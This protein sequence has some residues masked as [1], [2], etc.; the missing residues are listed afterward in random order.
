MAIWRPLVPLLAAFLLIPGGGLGQTPSAG[1]PAPV[2]PGPA[3]LTTERDMWLPFRDFDRKDGLRSSVLTLAVDPRGY[4]YA[5]TPE[6]VSRYNGQ[7]WT[8]FEI[9]HKGAP[10]AVY[11]VLGTSEGALWFG[12]DD[13][14]LYRHL[15]DGDN[16]TDDDWSQFRR[17]SGLPADHVGALAETVLGGYSVVWAGTESGLARCMSGRCTLVKSVQSYAVLSLLPST[18]QDG[19]PFLWIGTN[20][21]LL[22]LERIDGQDPVLAPV[23]FNQR[24]ALPGSA[25]RSLAETGSGDRRALWVGTDRGLSVLRNGIWTRYN[26]ASGFP[27]GRVLSL[28]P[29]SFEGKSVMWA[30]VFGSGLVLLTEDGSWQLFGMRSGLLANLVYSLAVTPPDGTLW[31]ATAAGVSRLERERWVLIDSRYG[32]PSSFTI[33]VGEA[34]FPDG[35]QTFWVGTFSGIARLT[36]DGWQRFTPR[37]GAESPVVLDATNTTEED[38]TR[39]F[40]MASFEG[41]YRHARGRW[42]LLD[43]SNS[44]LPFDWTTCLLATRGKKGDSLW[45][46][47]TNGLALLEQGRWT[48]FR[49]GSGPPGQK[50]RALLQTRAPGGA[51]AVWVGTD[52]GM[53]RYSGGRWTRADPPCLPH[54]GVYSLQATTRPDGTGWLWIGTRGGLARVRIDPQGIRPS[55]CQALTDAT[56]PVR[57]EDPWITQIQTDRYGRVYLFTEQG[58]F[59]LA[60][61]SQQNLRSA[62]VTNV[63]PEVRFNRA[64]FR[65]RFGRIWAASSAGAAILGP[66]PPQSKSAEVEPARLLFEETWVDGKKREL[67]GA[68]LRHD[69]NSLEIEYALLSYRREHDIRFQTQLDGLE[70][71]AG[72]WSREARTIFNKLPQGN[73]TFR[74]WAREADGEPLGPIEMKF[75]VLPAPWKTWW[76]ILLYALALTGL[77]YGANRLR[78][79]NL[80]RRAELLE[81]LVTDRTRELAEANRKLEMMSVTDPLTALHNRRFVALNLEADLQRAIRNYRGPSENGDRNRD[82]LLYLIDL[83]HFKKVNDRAGHIAGDA[84]LVEMARRLR[85]VVR[86]SDVVVR[87]GGE[88]FLIISRW[89]DRKAG[90]LLAS[91]ILEA[92][93]GKPFVASPDLLLTITC[94]IGWAPYPWNPESPEAL[95][96]DQVLALADRGLYLAKGGGRNRSVGVLPEGECLGETALTVDADFLDALDGRSVELEQ[97]VGPGAA[98]AA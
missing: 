63:L 62:L 23:H 44:P 51:S 13:R 21:G 92:V 27:K 34:E 36:Q 90:G 45:V 29:G 35:V 22:R 41:L 69:E 11:S 43:S 58:V 17:G 54:P 81:G 40:W 15:N 4:I 46:G 84:V 50:I 19:R 82:L 33:G 10:I 25:V 98:P 78:T 3:G 97:L 39:V 28:Q 68:V 56:E 73:Y 37:P 85:E 83:D 67:A 47:T 65:D 26:A 31:V 24:N 38:G 1:A 12:T 42:T 72:A 18:S 96:F 53:A 77:G 71:K 30:A 59:R 55:T 93:A 95:S 6:G 5:G 91:R 70:R 86:S 80:A 60:L 48:V 89:A 9:P 32:L 76:A 88:E 2:R 57:L 14:G 16:D 61:G 8:K 7:Q 87:W 79:R 20:H 52:E 94:S 66:Q 64:S 49:A 75:R 74:V